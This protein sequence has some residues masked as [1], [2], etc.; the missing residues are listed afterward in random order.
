MAASP[1]SPPPLPTR[2]GQPGTTSYC[3]SHW[4]DVLFKLWQAVLKETTP[5]LNNLGWG[6]GQ[7]TKRI[8]ARESLTQSCRFQHLQP[9]A[10]FSY[11]IF[12]VGVEKK[13][14]FTRR[15]LIRRRVRHMFH[16]LGQL[17][18]SARKT[19]STGFLFLFLRLLGWRKRLSLRFDPPLP[20][21]PALPRQLG[22]IAP[23]RTCPGWRPPAGPARMRRAA[24]GAREGAA[25][26]LGLRPGR[27]ESGK[28]EEETVWRCPPDAALMTELQQDV[29]D[30]K[31]AK[32]LGKRESKIGSA[33]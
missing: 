1:R 13:A 17:A 7:T 15:L 21:L 16:L 32:V 5:C 27:W 14:Q 20:S 11:T 31:P 18:S 23:A 25:G 4:T 10:H 24:Q 8:C 3:L 12:T 29:D 30:T 33:Q 19:S 22:P 28:R 9:A 26:S 6:T 2:K